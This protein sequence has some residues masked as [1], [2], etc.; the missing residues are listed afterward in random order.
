MSNVVI[1]T[2]EVCDNLA[3]CDD[4]AKA[5][6]ELCLRA[7]E[8]AAI[9]SESRS[10]VGAS[11]GSHNLGTIFLKESGFILKAKANLLWFEKPFITRLCDSPPRR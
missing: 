2:V 8:A 7:G 11:T 3:S 5:K 4:L 10:V 6:I 1:L 9:E